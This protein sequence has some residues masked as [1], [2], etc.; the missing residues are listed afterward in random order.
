MLSSDPIYYYKSL[1]TPT[2]LGICR[3]TRTH[4]H[5]GDTSIH[6]RLKIKARQEKQIQN[7]MNALSAQSQ[8]RWEAELQDL[9]TQLRIP[10]RYCNIMKNNDIIQILL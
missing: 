1:C 4:T 6:R 2:H 7:T 9:E 3:H 10:K 8:Q 5:V